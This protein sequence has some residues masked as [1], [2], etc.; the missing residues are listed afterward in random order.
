VDWLRVNSAQPEDKLN[1]IDRDRQ[2]NESSLRDLAKA[3]LHLLLAML[4][5]MAFVLVA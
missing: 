1:R 5:I 4:V 2:R 3:I